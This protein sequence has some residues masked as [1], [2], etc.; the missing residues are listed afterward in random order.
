MSADALRLVEAAQRESLLVAAIA[1]GAP[2]GREWTEQAH[3]RPGGPNDELWYP[4]TYGQ[5]TIRDAARMC[6][7]C[8]VRVACLAAALNVPDRDD[9]G[10]AAGTTPRHRKVMRAALRHGIEDC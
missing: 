5:D 8:P 1:H 4:R 3:C 6:R 10:V 2:A 7:H 9:H